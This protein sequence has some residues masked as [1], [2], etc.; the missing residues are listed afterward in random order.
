MN[1][2]RSYDQDTNWTADIDKQGDSHTNKTTV[3][4]RTRPFCLLF[5]A[6]LVPLILFDNSRK[7][8]KIGPSEIADEVGDLGFV[9]TVR[10]T[11]V[12]HP[13]RHVAVQLLK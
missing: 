8:I 2:M 3:D 5:L 4:D 1:N 10:L 6:M 7:E 9:V 11:G 13:A 12:R